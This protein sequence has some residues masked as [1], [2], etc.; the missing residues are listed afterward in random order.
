MVKTDEGNL[1]LVESTDSVDDIN[2]KFYGRFP[3][4]W[5]PARFDYLVDPYF[6][7]A[8]LNQNVGDWEHRAVPKNPKI[9]IAGCGTNQAIFTALRFPKATVLGSD[10]SA[11]SLKL[12]AKTAQELGI[13]NLELRQESLNHVAYKDRF[14]YVISTGVIH[15]NADPRGALEKLAG[16][17]KPTGILEL[18]VY[19]RYHRT[20]TT[21]FQKAI[22]ILGGDAAASVDFEAEIS[23]AKKLIEK[24]PAENL[25]ADFLNDYRD[26][27]EPAIADTLIQPVEYS[28]TVESLEEMADG[29]GLEFVAPCLNIFDKAWKTFSW[30]I[31]FG[32]AELQERYDAL[33]DSRRWQASNLLLFEKSPMLWFYL[34][35]KDGGRER[36]T[37]RQICEE[38]LET[39]FVRNSTTQKSYVPGEGGSYQPS[40]GTVAFPAPPADALIRKIVEAADG[41]T[42][43]RDIFQWLEISPAF[44]VVNQLRLRLTTSA[45]P[46]L[47]AVGEV[48]SESVGGREERAKDL[49]EATLQKFKNIKRRAVS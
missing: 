7:T 1:V 18:M 30:N 20:I 6:E 35:R 12:C 31:D 46:Y 48:E 28:Y 4:P 27:S 8:M 39:K 43:L 33:P 21:A 10:L 25:V 16:A 23:L 34:R 37:E 29:C 13:L 3:F 11:E 38:F 15:H 36:K 26:I 22:R 32:D 19:N 40:P 41:Q 49:K 45:F 5:R 42:P 47:R 9:W 2:A 14:D 17:V 44:H 24:F